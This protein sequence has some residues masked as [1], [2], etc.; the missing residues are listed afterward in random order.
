METTLFAVQGFPPTTPET[1]PEGAVL[2]ATDFFEW[3]S[4]WD[5]WMELTG[6]ALTT[7]VQYRRCALNFF[8]TVLV[9]PEH[10]TEEQVIDH[11]AALPARGSSRSALLR[12][13]RSFYRFTAERGLIGRDPVARLKPKREKYGPAPSL[14]RDEMENLLKAAETVDRRARWAIQFCYATGARVESLV[15]V[16]PDDLDLERE[17]VTF[18]VAKNDDPYGVPLGHTALEA[19]LE[20]LDLM[21][22][23]PRRGNHRGNLIGVGAQRFRGWLSEAA[24]LAGITKRVHPHLLRHTYATRLSEDPSVA[25]RTWQEL[26]NHKDMGQFRRYAAASDPS[27]RKAVAAL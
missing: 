27:M 16:E 21:D 1:I 19:A 2:E 4:R 18:R 12:A 20:L 14:T 5:T 26:M 10:L 22:Y 17:W 9:S 3:L 24:E 7:R 13:L 25:P 6:L 15:N 8:A 11:L 23:R